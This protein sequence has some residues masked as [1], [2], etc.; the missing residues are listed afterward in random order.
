MRT[1][2]SPDHAI[3][4]RRTWDARRPVRAALRR[5][6][7][8][9]ATVMYEQPDALSAHSLF[10]I[11]L[12]A[13]TFGRARLRALNTLALREGVNLAVTLKLADQDT[14]AWVARNALPH[15]RSRP[16]DLWTQLMED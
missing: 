2:A 3:K 16:S 1:P 8:S 4:A 6:E 11:L 12:M 13:H 9:I 15:A 5:G 14:R 7:L 10:E